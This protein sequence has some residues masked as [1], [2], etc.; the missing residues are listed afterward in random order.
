MGQDGFGPKRRPSS[1]R[2]TNLA[3]AGLATWLLIGPP[4][5]DGKPVP[6]APRGAWRLYGRF[7]SDAE[8]TRAMA[9]MRQV[10]GKGRYEWE[11]VYWTQL[12]RCVTDE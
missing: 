5:D 8:C 12:A 11:S 4:I 3:A 7:A 1:R 10:V 9:T 2:L 6:D